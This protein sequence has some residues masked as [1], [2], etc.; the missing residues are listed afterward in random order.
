MPIN[1]VNRQSEYYLVQHPSMA[2]RGRPRERQDAPPGTMGWRVKVA[3]ERLFPNLSQSAVAR[4]NKVSQS[5]WSEIES[6]TSKTPRISTFLKIARAVKAD[7]H[8]LFSGV[9]SEPMS[10]VVREIATSLDSL[11]RSKKEFACEVVLTFLTG[12]G[13]FEQAHNLQSKSP[14]N[15]GG[16]GAQISS[17][18]ARAPADKGQPKA[19]KGRGAKAGVRPPSGET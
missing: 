1:Q 6:G 2:T 17:E 4:R 15:N 16:T 9:P 3:R 14:N 5:V 18:A 10:V 12:L 19:R 7:P 11:P 8:E 13:Y